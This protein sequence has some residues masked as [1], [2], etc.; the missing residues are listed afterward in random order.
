[1]DV[2]FHQRAQRVIDHSMPL[3]RATAFESVRDDSDVEMPS[4]IPGTFVA[5]VQ[6]A[7]VL[8]QQL[9]W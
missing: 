4:T 3:Q 1:M 5:G 6:V 8:D 7:L 2:R 9:R